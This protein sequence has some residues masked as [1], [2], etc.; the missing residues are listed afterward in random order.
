MK[1]KTIATLLAIAM[2]MGFSVPAYAE[3]IPENAEQSQEQE[4]VQEETPVTVSTLVELQKAVAA[5]NK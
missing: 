3:D 5:E 4:L 2:I 1:R